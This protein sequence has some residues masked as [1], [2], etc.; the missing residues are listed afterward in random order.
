MWIGPGSRSRYS[1]R[2]RADDSN[3]HPPVHS[4][5]GSYLQTYIDGSLETVIKLVYGFTKRIP[6]GSILIFRSLNR[7]PK[8]SA[9]TAAVPIQG[10]AIPIY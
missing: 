8:F 4:F 3:G 9:L 5:Y 2:H 10:R 6:L 1:H 7:E